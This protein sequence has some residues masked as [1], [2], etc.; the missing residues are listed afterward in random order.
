MKTRA[1]EKLARAHYDD[2]WLY[3]HRYKR[4]S[5]DL[6]FYVNLGKKKGRVLE[7]GAG[8]GRITLPLARAGVEVVA[9]ERE[10]SLCERL[11]ERLQKEAPAVR[12]KVR[13]V[14]GDF[15]AA[16]KLKERF[17]WTLA[18]F[19][20]FS[21][22]YDEQALIKVLQVMRKVTK[23]L[24]FDVPLPSPETLAYD[25]DRR[26]RV[27]SATGRD[28]QKYAY[29]ESFDYDAAAQTL[30]ILAHYDAFD[31]T[32]RSSPD[33]R[34]S[35]VLPLL[36]R[37]HFPRELALIL[38]TAGFRVVKHDGG[39]AGEPLVGDSDSQVLVCR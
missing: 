35:F 4:R 23:Q 19:N 22:V 20:A 32:G 37:M 28:G 36:H 18:P 29:Y 27:G 2:P 38:R 21:H 24:A 31:P 15:R 14:Q 30:L 9:L 1:Q 5:L 39:F 13:I 11:R 10:A 8:T 17:E 33:H 3:D 6:A 7:L 26:Y 12:Q 16:A 34:A 25:P